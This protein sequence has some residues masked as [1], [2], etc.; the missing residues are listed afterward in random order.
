MSK[1][2]NQPYNFLKNI[3]GDVLHVLLYGV[4]YTFMTK[5]QYQNNPK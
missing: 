3:D 1:V 4:I 2:L 5:R